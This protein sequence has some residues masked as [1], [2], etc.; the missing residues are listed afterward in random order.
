LIL[1]DKYNQ[2]DQTKLDNIVNQTKQARMLQGVHYP[3]DCDAS[4]IFSTTLFNKLKGIFN[5]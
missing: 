2:I 4:L 5:E 1:K 3:S